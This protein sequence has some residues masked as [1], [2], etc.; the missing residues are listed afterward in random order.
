[1]SRHSREV[2]ENKRKVVVVVSLC[3]SHRRRDYITMMSLM[4]MALLLLSSWLVCH[5]IVST[6]P[7]VS[8]ATRIYSRRH[9]SAHRD[10]RDAVPLQDE[11]YSRISADYE[12]NSQE[13]PGEA[14]QSRSPSARSRL[15]RDPARQMGIEVQVR[16]DEGDTDYQVAHAG[17]VDPRLLDRPSPDWDPARM[18]SSSPTI[19]S[20]YDNSVTPAGFV[21]PRGPNRPSP[22]WDTARMGSS[23]PTTSSLFDNSGE[24]P[25]SRSLSERS[26]LTRDPARQ[27]DIEVQIRDAGGDINYRAAHAGSIDP[28]R[29]NRPSRYWDT[30]SKGSSSPTSSSHY[31]NSGM[32]QMRIPVGHLPPRQP[33]GIPFDR[34][35]RREPSLPRNR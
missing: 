33:S 18:G 8:S 31:D 15:S 26:R 20:H 32:Y 34:Q 14:P 7:A 16:D 1:M 3:P 30:P 24:A 28:R 35:G 9:S 10:R 29:L 6:V 25:Q 12:A 22:V 19:S 2:R 21:D 5:S 13:L 23:S 17:S 11:D 27:T 4:R